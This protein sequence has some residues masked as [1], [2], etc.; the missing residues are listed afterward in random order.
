MI[1]CQLLQWYGLV[2]T[3]DLYFLLNKPKSAS[4][5]SFQVFEEE[6]EKDGEEKGGVGE[7]GA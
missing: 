6:E 4:I 7:G 5:Y 1:R 2:R 3:S